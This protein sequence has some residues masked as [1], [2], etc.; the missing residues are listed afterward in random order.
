MDL[1]RL[2]TLRGTKTSFL[3]LRTELRRAPHPLS[4]NPN[5]FLLASCRQGFSLCL[6]WKNGN[7]SRTSSNSHLSATATFFISMDD[8]CYFNLSTT[9]TS[10]QQQQPLKRV[11]S[12]KVTSPQRPV[13]QQR[14]NGVY[15]TSFVIGHGHE[16]ISVPRVVSLYF[17]LASLL[18][19][20]FDCVTYLHCLCYTEYFFTTKLLSP[21]KISVS[22]FTLTD[23]SPYN[24]HFPMSPR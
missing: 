23:T 1:K 9:A 5:C 8:N 16:T 12:A 3:T 20:Y 4:G 6:V 10:P 11:P 2:N 15:K 22:C 17:C 14:T 21:M 13:N 18:L 7:Y 19:I 24:G